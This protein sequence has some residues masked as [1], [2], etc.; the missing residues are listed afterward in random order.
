MLNEYINLLAVPSKHYP[1]QLMPLII[2]HIYSVNFGFMDDQLWNFL[3]LVR[4]Y[5]C[6][7]IRARSNTI[8]TICELELKKTEHS[9]PAGKSLTH[10]SLFFLKATP[11]IVYLSL[12]AFLSTL[13][14]SLTFHLLFHQK[15]TNMIFFEYF[16]SY[17]LQIHCKSTAIYVNTTANA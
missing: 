6:I 14:P 4:I 10:P 16:P 2:C 1:G 13:S 5:I 17:C 3:I 15:I 9:V 11:P 8:I 12:L 7:K